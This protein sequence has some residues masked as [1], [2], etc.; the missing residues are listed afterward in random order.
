MSVCMRSDTETGPRESTV[1][2]RESAPGEIIGIDDPLPC[3]EGVS[4]RNPS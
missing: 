4:D 2:T 1:L 3:W